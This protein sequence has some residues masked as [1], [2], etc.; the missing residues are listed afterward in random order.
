MKIEIDARKTE[1]IVAE[2][3]AHRPGFVPEWRPSEQGPDIAIAQIFARY[4]FA[5]LQRLNQAPEKNKL[6][7]LD[8][9]GI[10][11]ISAQGARA[12]VVFQMAEQ[13]APTRVNAGS[14]VAAPPPQGSADQIV[15]EIERTT[16]L[17]PA[18][19][20]E[21]FSLW[22]GRDQYIDHSAAVLAGQS[23]EPFK[24]FLLQDTPHALYLA[25]DTLL[26]LAG[27]S[28]LEVEVELT[29][30]SS[31]RLDMAFE[32]WDGKVWRG[33][34]TMQ[35][36]CAEQGL[37]EPDG[38]IGLT[39]SGKCRLETDCAE[40]AKTAINGINAF[41]IRGRLTEPLPPDPGN[42]LPEVERVRL[43]TVIEREMTV[44]GEVENNNNEAQALI[45]GKINDSTKVSGGF[46]PDKAFT[47]GNAV[48]LSKP[49]YPFGLQPQPGV[50]FYFASEEIF[51]KPGASMSVYVKHTETPQDQFNVTATSTLRDDQ[52]APIKLS[53]KTPISHTLSWEYWNGREWAV[54]L[55]YSNA[56][57]KPETLSPNDFSE[58]GIIPFLIPPDMAR[59]KIN[60][61]ESL[62]MRV[63]L[64]SGGFGFKQ[65]VTWTDAANHPNDFTYVIAQPPALA[66]FRLGYTW[67]YG[68]FHPEYV[69]TYNDF[70]YE[71]HTED[72]K[73]PGQT[74]QPYKTVHDVTPA[75]YLGFDKKL[76][77]D[78]VS[79]Y[80]D[81]VEQPGETDGPALVWEYWDGIDWRNL[82]VEDE[83]NNLRV[84]GMLS[85]IGPADAEALARFNASLYWVR[86]RLK[87]DGPPGEPTVN[88]I[89]PNAVWAVQRQTIINESLGN[90]SGQPN[91]VFKFR[92][93][94]V[95]TGER[96]EVRELLGL[97]ANVEWRSLVMETSGGDI[98]VVREL[99]KMLAREGP[100]SEIE[101]GDLRLV[102]NQNKRVIEVWVRWHEQQHLFLAGPHDRCFAVERVR[103]RLRFGNGSEGKVPPEGAAIIARRYQSGGGLRGNVGAAT[104]TQMLA[105]IA[106]V[107]AVSNPK[108][109]EG[110]ADAETLE[111]L[112]LRG[113]QTIR[114][115]GRALSPQDYETLTREASTAVAFVRAIPSR[116]ASGRKM[117][118]WVTLLIIPQSEEPRPRPSFGL[119]E[120]VRKFIEARVSADL[121]ASGHI[122]VTGPEYL[123]ID[124]EATIAPLN[125]DEAGAVEQ[126]AREALQTFFHP[127][128][129][130][131]EGRGWELGRDVFISDVA[132]VLERVEG[133]DYVRELSLLL[134]G[135]LQREQVK[136]ADNRIVV[137]GEIKIK[138]IE[139]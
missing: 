79:L 86:A 52:G 114:H 103:G 49:F 23:F 89:R 1:E 90:S 106:G 40:T 9:L 128:R 118:G 99:E 123:E 7:F 57:Q 126:R 64:L 110:G 60:D 130:G 87:E 8:L 28:I 6:A 14:Q 39:R 73:W 10:E 11:L 105:P 58:T 132:S 65:L 76:P 83:T 127:L 5:I 117:P 41:W 35:R 107:Q 139:G 85:F 70:Q 37:L 122:Y 121:A 21:V 88:T 104:I 18:R 109:A 120:Q 43:T 95:H 135:A 54:L 62:W 78:R 44:A 112:S 13:S 38:T 98:S 4:L 67:Q 48:D 115:R 32:Y 125:V 53:P 108:P 74:F 82:S 33:F 2:V 20:Q 134:D 51:S 77:T 102:R 92:L 26:A 45:S 137:V 46:A 30:P 29:T 133:V 47:D 100:A 94:P 113:P 119:R 72:S 80:F 124:I 36:E 59:S 138:L 56:P 69:L 68:P 50:A 19:L 84:P 81:I 55:P 75:L 61:Q 63:R 34:K 101:K 3:L 12:P 25:H 24:K 111:S 131:P 22:A 97:R 16:A 93:V 27:K 91:Q 116:A 136:V 42:T 17:S 66:D 71:D 129:G 96:I 31:K 15:F